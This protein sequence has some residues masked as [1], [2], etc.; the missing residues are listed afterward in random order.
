MFGFGYFI[1]NLYWI[2]NSLTFEE[3]FKSTN[4]NNSKVINNKTMTNWQNL[5]DK[6]EFT[7]KLDAYYVFIGDK[8]E[9]KKPIL[10][11]DRIE[12]IDYIKG[13][14]LKLDYEFYITNQ[15]MKPVTQIFNLLLEQMS[16]F[17]KKTTIARYKK[18]LKIVEL[19]KTARE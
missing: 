15:I 7:S 13:K 1:S 3:N 11:G 9:K 8:L 16:M 4:N 18:D 6:D 10:Q 14:N 19:L 17:N 12:H 2:T 5:K